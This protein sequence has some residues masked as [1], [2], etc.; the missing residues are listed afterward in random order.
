MKRRSMRAVDVVARNGLSEI[1]PGN[2]DARCRI[3]GD[4][5]SVVITGNR[6][7]RSE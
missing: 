3:T 6:T 4:A 1:S 2:V 5:A 7:A